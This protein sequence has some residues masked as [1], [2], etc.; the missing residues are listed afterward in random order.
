MGSAETSK[1]S[2]PQMP[3]LINTQCE[4]DVYPDNQE[5]KSQPKPERFTLHKQGISW[6]TERQVMGSSNFSS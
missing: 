3:P 2:K 5:R 1:Q 4:A 6:E